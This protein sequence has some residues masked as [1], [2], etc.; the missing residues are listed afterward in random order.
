MC[1]TTLGESNLQ[2]F[3]LPKG[4]LLSLQPCPRSKALCICV[5]GFKKAKRILL[6]W[7]ANCALF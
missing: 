6:F 2:G 3:W 1:L 7:H 4:G 5:L